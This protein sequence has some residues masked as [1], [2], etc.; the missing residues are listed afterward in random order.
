MTNSCI[1]DNLIINAIEAC[2]EG[3]II[4]VVQ[5]SSSDEVLFCVEDNGPGIDSQ[6]FDLIFNAGYSTKFSPSTGKISTGLGLSHVKIF[7]ELLSGTIR[8]ESLPGVC[9][10]FFIS[11][12][13]TGIVT[14]W[15][16]SGNKF[17]K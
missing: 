10:R 4:R 16:G 9:T 8:V 5:T 14:S 17:I 6:E 12:P 15:I 7:V 2:S 13:Y 11:F 3:A 1:L